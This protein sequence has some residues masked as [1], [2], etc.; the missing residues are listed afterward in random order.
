[1]FFADIYGDHNFYFGK[2]IYYSQ[3]VVFY[4]RKGAEYK[5]TFNRFMLIM[6]EIGVTIEQRD[7][8]IQMYAMLG[9]RHAKQANRLPEVKVIPHPIEMKHIHG[10]LIIY[11]FGMSVGFAAFLYE[12][13]D[14]ENW[15]DFI[16]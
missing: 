6:N 15:A 3:N 1:M 16:M 9:K 2:K 4:I 11:V 10:S 8:T 14:F 7:K 5:E 12:V 13:I